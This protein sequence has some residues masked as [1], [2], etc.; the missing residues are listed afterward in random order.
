MRSNGSYIDTIADNGPFS[1]GPSLR[2]QTF[3]FLG[4]VIAFVISVWKHRLAYRRQKNSN[5]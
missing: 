2:K 4:G 3:F 1:V 5:H